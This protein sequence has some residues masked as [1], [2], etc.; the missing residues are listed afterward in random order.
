MDIT[1]FVVSKRDAAFLVGDYST[2]RTQLSRRILTVRKRLG[3]TTPKNSKFAKKEPVT[4]EDIAKDHEF[5][6]LLLLLSERARA[7]ALHMK[8]IHA[9]DN[10]G[11][12]I[13]GSSRKH[14]LSRLDKASKIARELLD[15]LSNNK[16]TTGATDTDVLEARAYAASLSGAIEFE[17]QS[18]GV[19]TKKNASWDK[20]LV[21]LSTARVIYASL[22]QATKK[23]IFKE[24]L[25]STIDPS[26]RYAAYQSNIPRTVSVP[27]VSKKYFPRDDKALVSAVESLDPTTFGGGEREVVSEE[28]KSFAGTDERI[29]NTIAWRGRTAAIVDASI[30]QALAARTSAESRLA[31]TLSSQPDAPPRERAAAYD[32]VLIAA[33]DAADATRRAIEELEKENVDP[34]DSRFQDL[35]VTSLAV[36]YDLIG[37]RVGRNRTLIGKDDGLEFEPQSV[38]KRKR[39]DAMEVDEGKGAVKEKEQGKGKKLSRLRERVV[40]LD[41]ILQSIDSI[42]ELRGAMR[43]AVFIEELEAKRGYF[44]ALKCLNIARSHALLASPVN[45]LALFARAESL[46]AKLLTSDTSRNWTTELAVVPKLDFSPSQAQ[47]LHRR[48]TALVLQYRALVDLKNIYAQNAKAAKSDTA[49]EPLVERLHEF[50]IDG[51]DLK[52]IV[53]WPPRLRPVPVKP[54][55][56]D[57]AWNYIDYPGRRAREVED[58]VG[59]PNGAAEEEEKKPAKKGW[60]G[61]G[62]S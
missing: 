12:G 16:D 3:R 43:D 2:Y 22:L 13:S 52:N 59:A 61:F 35:H 34:S 29:P 27:S 28:G 48:L 47:Q 33:Q 14:I 5:V 57:V 30:G 25:A 39:P 4:A 38:R 58:R 20:C 49:P 32:D 17:K 11:Q 18:Q 7:H 50:P 6:R 15:L 19:G 21:E 26:I 37:L 60:F 42:K 31:E 24:L 46:S 56:F 41:A 44:Q 51:V 36:N 54:L 55:F 23:D 40:L 62:R 45:A 1:Q 9:E 8:S 53:T 10:H